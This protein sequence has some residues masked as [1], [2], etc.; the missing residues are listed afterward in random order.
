MSKRKL[1]NITCKEATFLSS[2]K[3][4]KRLS[5]HERFLLSL[6]LKRCAPCRRFIDQYHH[7]SEYLHLYKDRDLSLSGNSLSLQR[8]STMQQ[9]IDELIKT[10]K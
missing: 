8:K 3:E 4:E 5:F 9:K 10:Q 1:F 7:I 2:K 6:H